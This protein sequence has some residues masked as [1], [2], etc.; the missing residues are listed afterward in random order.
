[1]GLLLFVVGVVTSG[2]VAVFARQIGEAGGPV[3]VPVVALMLGCVIGPALVFMGGS[4]LY[5]AM[6][7]RLR[8][9][10]EE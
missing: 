8:G 6:V 5:R 7:G 3:T 10:S 2:F 1:M 4:V 9:K